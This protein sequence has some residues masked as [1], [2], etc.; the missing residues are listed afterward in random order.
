MKIY[1][2]A[3][4]DDAVEVYAIAYEV[5]KDG[6][7][8]TLAYDEDGAVIGFRLSLDVDGRSHGCDEWIGERYL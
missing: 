6:V 8:V 3:E 2:K 5:E 7:D 1:T 4:I